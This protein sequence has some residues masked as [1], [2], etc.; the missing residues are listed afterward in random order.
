[1]QPGAFNADAA[2]PGLDID[3]PNVGYAENGKPIFERGR[4]KEGES[5]ADGLGG[6][7]GR[8]VSRTRNRRGSEGGSRGGYGRVEQ[9]ES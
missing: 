8:M 6:W 1:M 7:I 9:D 5:D 2:I 4:K 3:P